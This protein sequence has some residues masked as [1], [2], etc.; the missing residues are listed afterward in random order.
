M[1]KCE[2]CPRRCSVNREIEK[3]FCGEKGVRIAHAMLHRW[4][5]PI[6]SGQ[7]GSGAIFFSGCN[8]KC[9][10]CQNY[11]LSRGLIGKNASITDLVDLLKKSLLTTNSKDV[12]NT[13]KNFG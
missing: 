10:Y 3:G 7:N 2:L 1:K 11:E 5:E 13:H 6:I 12:T 8:M 9:V 4:E